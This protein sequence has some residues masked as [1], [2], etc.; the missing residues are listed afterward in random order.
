MTIPVDA[1][2]K[3][4]I[5]ALPSEFS[6]RSGANP[7]R[8]WLIDIDSAGKSVKLGETP[9]FRLKELLPWKEKSN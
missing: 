3:L 4:M 6:N 2:V 9:N 1:A 8:S 5:D 7:L